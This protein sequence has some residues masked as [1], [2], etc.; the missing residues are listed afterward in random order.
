MPWPRPAPHSSPSTPGRA[1]RPPACTGKTAWWSPPKAL[2]GGRTTSRSRS[3]TAGVSRRSWRG[4]APAPTSPSCAS[5]PGHRP[6][7]RSTIP[8]ATVNR[9]VTVLLER[10]YVARGWIGAAM[11]PVRLDPATEQRLKREAGLLL[12]SVEPDAPASRA[13]LLVGD[14]VVAI[15]GKDV[16]GFD[17]LLDVLGGDVVGKKLKLAV[18]RAGQPVSVDVVIDERPRRAR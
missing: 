9:V 15:D 13:G 4:A 14:I 2:S 10:G 7:Q 11:Q 5:R 3:R 8:V 18:V 17:Q 12:L 16:D 6:W 1:C